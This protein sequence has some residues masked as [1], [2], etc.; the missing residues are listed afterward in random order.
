LTLTVSAATVAASVSTARAAAQPLGLRAVTTA[1]RLHDAIAELAGFNDDPDAG[2]ITREVYTPTYAAALE[3][4]AEW[5]REA[6]LEMRLDAVGN[7][8]G[9]WEGA[10]PGAA[11]VITG[12]HVDTTLNAG[13]YDG[14]VGVLG[15][16]EAVHLLR[17]EGVVPRRTIELVAWAGEEPRFGT[18]CDGTSVAAALRAAGFDPDRLAEA[19]ID[20]AGV[21]ALVELHIEQGAV[22]EDGGE[23]IGV[24]GAIAAPHDFRLTLRGAATHSGATPMRLRRDALA[25]AAEA[26]TELERIARE[27]PSGTTV[28]TVGVIRARPGAINVVPGEVELDVDVRDSDLAARTRVVDAVVEAARTIA[29]RRRLELEVEPIV[30]DVPVECDPRVVAA[31]AEAA[32]ALGLPHRRMISGAYHDA[33]IMGARVPIGMIFVPSAGGISHHP[34]EFTD[35]E[36]VERGVRVLAGTLARLAA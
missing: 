26:M 8:F 23:P 21:H 15:A 34:D 29:A 16:I 18:G 3:R 17:D 4:V 20:P 14:V 10:E 6:G 9:R 19:E 25:G 30:E 32:H 36:D 35:P 5:M 11:R 22:L 12:S 33:M 27:S 2:G 28:G 31:A 13:R 7:L 24:V 1:T